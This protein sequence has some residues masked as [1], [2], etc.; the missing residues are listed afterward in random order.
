MSCLLR[1]VKH[2]FPVVVILASLG[3]MTWEIRKHCSSGT[4]W[5][6][7]EAY[8]QS[9]RSENSTLSDKLAFS[10]LIFVTVL[11]SLPSSVFEFGAGF[12]FRWEALLVTLPA[13]ILG[14][15][16]CFWL[17]R[18]CWRDLMKK[19]L[20]HRPL[21]QGLE[22]AFLENERKFAFL[23]RLMS[24]PQF[25]RN[26]VAAI[27]PLRFSVYLSASVVVNTIY[28][29]ANVSVGLS[30][31]SLIEAGNRSSVPSIVLIS[32]AI[33]ITVGALVWISLAVRR[34]VAKLPK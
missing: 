19:R 26:Y 18:F 3:Y 6:P 9:L 28:G 32:T 30:S 7:I 20:S 25:F 31:A 34:Q 2:I 13:K 11:A 5:F 24:V 17:G 10:A 22:A 1:V 4:S 12:F 23:L 29:V 14:S 33:I 21:F 8:V 15:V 16:V 27:L